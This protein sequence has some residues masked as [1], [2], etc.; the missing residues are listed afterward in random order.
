[1]NSLILPLLSLS[2]GATANPG[3]IALQQQY[4]SEMKLIRAIY[5]ALLRYD[6]AHNKLPVRTSIHRDSS[7]HACHS[8]LGWPCGPGRDRLSFFYDPLTASLVLVPVGSTDVPFIF[9][10]Q[11][12]T[13]TVS[14]KG[15]MT[16]ST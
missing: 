16:P 8:I 11:T 4:G 9:E 6:E 13:I 7:H 12:G 10:E 1:M 2:L 14:L 5:P 15:R 3:D